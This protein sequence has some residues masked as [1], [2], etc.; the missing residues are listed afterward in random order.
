MRTCSTMPSSFEINIGLISLMFNYICDYLYQE[1]YAA[2]I[3]NTLILMLT[4]VLK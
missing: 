3:C 4:S 1:N 2:I